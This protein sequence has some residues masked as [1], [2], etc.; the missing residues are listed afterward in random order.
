MKITFFIGG[1]SKGGAE[2]VVCNLANILANRGHEI[3]VLTMSDDKPSY[4]IEDK[5]IRVPLLF[6]SERKNF[7]YNSVLRLCRFVS[8]LRKNKVDVYVV[9]LPVTTI[10]LLQLR[11]ITKAKVIAAERNNPSKYPINRQKLLKILARKADGWVF[12]TR[13]VCN[14]YGESTENSKVK[15]IPNAINPEFIQSAY[16]G[17]R[18]KVIVSAG[19]MDVQKNQELLIRAFSIISKDFADYKLIIYGEG[20][21]RSTLTTVSEELGIKDKVEIPGYTTNIGEK[22]KDASLFVLSSDF[23]GM[24]NA[25]MEAMALGLPCISTDSDGGGARFLIDNEKNGLLVP[26][27]DVDS[28]AKAMRRMLHDQFFAENCGREARKICERLAPERI[29]GEWER[30][31]QEV[32]NA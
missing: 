11:F 31:I 27:G 21:M 1:L 28:L 32:V 4:T 14:W 26:K 3:T 17:E 30:Y 29:Y 19:R 23:E 18:R 20:E 13:E 5:V 24:P 25:L 12:Q 15:I 16:T 22:I 10:M 6:T 8:Y 2:R 7:V 9:M